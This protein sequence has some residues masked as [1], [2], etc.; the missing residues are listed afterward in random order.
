MFA[1]YLGVIGLG[2]AFYRLLATDP[3]S[4]N[5]NSSYLRAIHAA[6]LL[7]CLA[8]GSNAALAQDPATNRVESTPDV[9][10]NETNVPVEKMWSHLNTS[11]ATGQSGPMIFSD[12]VVPR[13][14]TNL[15]DA[16]VIRGNAT[17]DG[18][19]H[20]DSV[21]VLGDATLNGKVTGDVVVVLGS[22]LGPQA[23][24]GGQVVVV[25]GKLDRAPG[26][27]TVPGEVVVLLSNIPGL[28]GLI[29]WLS[30]GLAKGRLFPPNVGWVWVVAAVC[31][32]INL[33]LLLLF[34][35][36][37]QAC[38]NTMEARPLTSFLRA[39]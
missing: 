3:L 18:E 26:A 14:Q 11:F 12:L 29:E 4:S 13:G 17:I 36:P 21:T 33:L 39:Y 8:A 10:T 23:E 24:V 15:D 38:V 2:T 9:T 1:L 37:L 30:E 16:M 6:G 34:P 35:R 27:K 19:V 5:E 7:F 31:L 32:G 25:G 28:R 22:S 20:G